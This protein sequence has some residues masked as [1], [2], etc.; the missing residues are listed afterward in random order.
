MNDVWLIV[1][2]VGLFHLYEA[3]HVVRADATLLVGHR[4]GRLR[5]V[6]PL[7]RGLPLGSD[8]VLVL[9]PLLPTGRLLV[10]DPWPVRATRDGLH[11]WPPHCVAPHLPPGGSASPIPWSLVGQVER[12]GT[13]LELAGQRIPL[14]TRRGAARWRE[15]LR[16]LAGIPER[17]RA[18]TIEAWLRQD[19]ST[20]GARTRAEEVCRRVT[21]LRWIGLALFLF[22]FVGLPASQLGPGPSP[23]VLALAYLALVVLAGGSLARALGR[24]APDERAGRW[25]RPLILPL[26]PADALRAG[27]ELE[28]EGLAGFHPLAS[29]VA[30]AGAPDREAFLRRT[31]LG[32]HHAPATWTDPASPRPSS[33]WRPSRA[34][35]SSA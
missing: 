14:S 4:L 5:V 16:R 6:D 20:E 25:L 8:R 17:E 12:R 15:R 31:F 13:S 29:V 22:V 10:M 32:L 21:P 27:H 30:L 18:G 19:A 33:S 34:W 3:L 23:L 7:R 11:P 24:V 35:T 2:V 9:G 26:Y 28:R 1:L